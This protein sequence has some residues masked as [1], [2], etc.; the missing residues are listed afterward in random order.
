[1]IKSKHIIWVLDLWPDVLSDLKI[2]KKNSYFYNLTK[3]LVEYIYKNSDYILCQ[4]LSFKRK[5]NLINKNFKKKTLYFPSWPEINNNLVSKQ[6]I[7][8]Q[9]IFDSKKFNLIFTGNIGDAQNFGLI[10]ELVKITVDKINW[11]IAGKGRRYNSLVSEKKKNKLDNLKLLGL[12]KFNELIKYVNQSDALL[13]SLKKGDAFDST[14]PGKF[15]TYLTFKKRII[16]LIGGEVNEIVKKYSLGFATNENEPEKIKF[17]LMN[18][19]SKEFDKV[20]FEKN[21]QILEKIYS[22]NRNI[23]KLINFL[24]KENTDILVNYLENT[25]EIPFDRNFILSAFNLAFCGALQEENINLKTN[26]FL[27]WPDGYYFNKISKL[28]IPKLPGRKLVYNLVLPKFIEEIVV[29]GNLSFKGVAYLK[30]KF[31]KKIIN[32]KLPYGN[33]DN[34]IEHV[35]NLKKNQLCI[36]TLPTP[37]QEILANHISETQNNYKILCVGGAINMLTGEEPPVPEN[38]EKIFVG[39]M[40]WRLQFETSRRIKRLIRSFNSYLK[41]KNRGVYNK[42]R[43]KKINEK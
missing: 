7:I 4:S 29:I 20:L 33:I 18:Y 27:V 37:K 23:N 12:L 30:K 40:I 24:K 15:Q 42:L 8:D 3:K 25:H 39:E 38:I 1:M 34:F 43:F 5:I 28:Q 2:L 19:L 22:K 9:N 41:G 32:I 35:P 6:K 36:L 17:S 26:K 21:I 14:I 31:K 10:L 11:I 13:I 16:A